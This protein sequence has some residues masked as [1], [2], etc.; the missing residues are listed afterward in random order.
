MI[1]HKLICQTHKYYTL[2]HAVSPQMM[3]KETNLHIVGWE[4]SYSSLPLSFIP[5]F[6]NLFHQVQDIILVE[7]Q[8]PAISNV[9]YTDCKEGRILKK[10]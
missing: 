2:K 7:R 1:C 10:K 3:R 8:F 4:N 9:C 6:V 5:V